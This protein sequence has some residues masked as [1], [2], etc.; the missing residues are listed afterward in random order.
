MNCTE[1]LF[2]RGAAL[3]ASPMGGTE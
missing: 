2:R 3:P 1:L